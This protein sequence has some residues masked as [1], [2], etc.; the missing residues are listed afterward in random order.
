MHVSFQKKAKKKNGRNTFHFWL[1]NLYSEMDFV[2]QRRYKHFSCVSDDET[3]NLEPQVQE[4]SLEQ[5]PKIQKKTCKRAGREYKKRKNVRRGRNSY[6]AAKEK[7]LADLSKG[8]CLFCVLPTLFLFFLCEYVCVD[9]IP[10]PCAKNLGKKI[11]RLLRSGTSVVF[12]NSLSEGLLQEL[13]VINCV[14]SYDEELQVFC[15]KL[16]R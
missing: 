7:R 15:V 12:R 4:T 5:R 16:R 14:V 8:L 11:L 6:I 9:M 3:E 2:P 10:N 13:E 1:A